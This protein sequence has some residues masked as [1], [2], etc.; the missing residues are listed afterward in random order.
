MEAA[1]ARIGKVKVAVFGDFCLDAY[2]IIEPGESEISVETGLPV[3]RVQRQRYSLG[4]AGNVVANLTALGVAEVH[5]VGLTGRDL[6]GRQMRELLGELHV[7]TDGLLADQADW[8]TL[9][10]AKPCMDF[11][12]LNRIDFGAFNQV[13]DPSLEALAA[14]L[15]QVASRVDVVVVNQQIPAGVTTAAMIERL[16]DIIARH[17]KCMFLADSRHRA[18]L[19]TGAILKMNAHEAA[20]LLG[21][22]RPTDVRIPPHIARDLAGDLTRRTNKPIFITRSEHGLVVASG[23]DVQEIPGIQVTGRI[24]PVGAGDTVLATLAAAL[25]AGCDLLAA[26]R[27]ANVAASLTV[28]KL[29]TTGTASPAEIHAVGPHPDYI[30]APEL[31]DDVR[32]IRYHAATEIEIVRAL[33]RQVRIRHALFDHDGTLSTLREGWELVMAPMMVAAILGPKYASADEALYLNVVDTVRRYIDKTTGIQTLVQMAGLVDLVRQ[34]RCVPEADI[35]DLH[36]YKAL[37]NEA[38]MKVVQSRLEKLG[39][40]ELDRSDFQ[41]KNALPLLQRLHAAGVKLYL[42]SGTDH[43]D[44]VAEVTA[45][46][47]ADLFENRIYGAVGDVKVEAKREVLQRI[48][49]EHKVHGPELAVF[50]DGPVEIREARKAEAIAVGLASDEVRRFGLNPKKRA[51]LVRAGADLIV[52]DFSQTGELLKLLGVA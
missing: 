19:F 43:A 26:A 6:F 27:L 44:V 46:G 20:R 51:R 16:N 18:E 11:R 37:Y 30:F 13:S 24:D 1:L 32:Q 40:G 7:N 14:R 8:E 48:I 10:Y 22:P 9:V 21:Q 38:L 2:W 31:A 5:A 36:G 17:P 35:L 41:V 42:A 12:E 28:Q 50:G 45:M 4:G 15:E 34:F 3:R 49:R 33:P 23:D 25:G 39:R 52:P 29:L 47:Y